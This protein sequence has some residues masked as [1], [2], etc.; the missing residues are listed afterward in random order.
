MKYCTFYPTT[1]IQ[2]GWIVRRWAGPWAQTRPPHSPAYRTRTLRQREMQRKRLESHDKILGRWSSTLCLCSWT[3]LFTQEVKR[4]G[5]K[6]PYFK[7]LQN[8]LSDGGIDSEPLSTAHLSSTLKNW[9]V[10][11]WGFLRLKTPI[12]TWTTNSATLRM[13]SRRDCLTMCT[14]W[15]HPCCD[16]QFTPLWDGRTCTSFSKCKLPFGSTANT[17]DFWHGKST[18]TFFNTDHLLNTTTYLT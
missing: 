8:C 15:H 2:H 7:L 18:L 10:A 17:F 3:A 12:L 13:S 5:F 4:D 14:M 16:P 11:I 6:G 1:L 9:E